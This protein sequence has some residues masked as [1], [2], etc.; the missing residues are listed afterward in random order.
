MEPE[1]KE[2]LNKFALLLLGGL[3]TL[4]IYGSAFLL[5]V[6]LI[7]LLLSLFSGQRP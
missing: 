5:I 6:W 1:D 2:P 7:N 4:L 3:L